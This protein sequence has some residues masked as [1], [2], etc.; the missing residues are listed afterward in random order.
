MVCLT[1][2]LFLLAY[3]H[4]NVGWLGLAAA[5]SPSR[6]HPLPCHILSP[7]RL[8]ISA[9]PTSLDECFFFKSLVVRLPCSL[10]FWQFWLVFVFKLVIVILLVVP[11]SKVYLPMPPSWLEAPSPKHFNLTLQLYQISDIL[12]ILR[13]KLMYTPKVSLLEVM[14]SYVT[15]C[16]PH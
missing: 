11:G 10:I 14:Y 3:P 8:P 6:S 15:C 9:P 7:P 1:P 5:A 13:R 4:T 16:S 12:S 2:Q